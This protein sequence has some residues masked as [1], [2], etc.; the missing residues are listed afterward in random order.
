[1]LPSR[2]L[3]LSLC[4]APVLFLL[5]CDE[6]PKVVTYSVPK[7]KSTSA[8]TAPAISS[9]PMADA[10]SSAAMS[11]AGLPQVSSAAAA[12]FSPGPVPAHWRADT[13]KPMRQGSWSIPGPDGSTADW[14]ITVFPGDVG[15]DLANVNRWR[16][17]IQLGPISAAE[18]PAALQPIS[19]GGIPG[20]AVLLPGPTQT[21]YGIIL[22]R[23][24]ETWF[25]KFTGTAAT[26]S[27]EKS[28][29]QSFAEGTT[30]SN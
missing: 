22:P 29:L 19:V 26:F 14:S 28:S 4:L 27:S 16:G 10:N 17:Q 8:P 5:G 23:G 9:A 6:K 15:G 7:E 2:P 12:Q 11:A 21:V 13:D 3:L 30:F 25:F 1:M 18:L 20:K 24:P